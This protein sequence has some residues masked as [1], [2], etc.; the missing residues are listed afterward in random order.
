[1]DGDFVA[2]PGQ[3]AAGHLSHLPLQDSVS[4]QPYG[5]QHDT[6]R[7]DTTNDTTR[8]TTRH[9]T[10]NDMT[11]PTTRHDQR[12]DTTNDTTNDTTRPTT[13]HDTTIGD[14]R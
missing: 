2:K 13:R 10:T 11:R 8:P 1:M 12:H 4:S 5:P 14:K 9:D 3:R 7:H 6:T